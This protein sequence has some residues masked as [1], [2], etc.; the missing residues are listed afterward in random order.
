MAYWQW[1][2]PLAAHVIVCVH[3]LSRQGRDFDVLTQA[4]LERADHSLRVV[5]P[6][7]AGRGRSDWLKDPMGYQIPAY[8]GDML[9]MIALLHRQAAVVTLDWLGTSMGGLIGMAVAGT[10]KLPLPVP[11]RRLVLNDVGPAIQWQALQRIGTYLGSTGRFETMEQAA[12]A[13]WAISTS[14]GPHTPQQWLALSQPM[15]RALPDGGFTLHY[16]PAIAVPFRTVTEESAAQ[17]E[18]ALWHLYD[19]I[20]AE[21]LVTRG[22]NSDLLSRETA[23]AMT[24]RGPKARLAEFEGVGHAPTFVANNQ[25][26]VVASFLLRPN[27]EKFESGAR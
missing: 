5:C 14:F 20:G 27:N 18:A 16:D 3:G 19:N 21:V 1:G 10:P 15:V 24:Q 26:E 2:D 7:V 13:M 11:L 9:A 12:A 23:Q 17:G 6:D 25:I 8:A 22:A 4:L